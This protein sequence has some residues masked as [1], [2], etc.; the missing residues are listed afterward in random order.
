MHSNYLYLHVGNI[1]KDV[2]RA[3]V[4][5]WFHILLLCAN[6]GQ[7]KEEEKVKSVCVE[8]GYVLWKEPLKLVECSTKT[9]T[10]TYWKMGT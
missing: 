4:S 9:A 5:A 1:C 6:L 8:V 2:S 3:G 10:T 7:K